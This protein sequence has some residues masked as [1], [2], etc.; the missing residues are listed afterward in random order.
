MEKQNRNF[1]AIFDMDGVIIDNNSHHKQAWLEFCKK[2]QFSLAEDGFNKHIYGRTNKDILNLLFKRELTLDDINKYAEEKEAMYREIYKPHISLP[3]GLSN[4]LKTLKA[5]GV[6]T[7]VA[8]SAPRKNVDF[9]FEN[10]D[11]KNYFDIIV[12]ETYVV[13]NKPAP[14]IYLKASELLGVVPGKCVVIEDSIPGITA[15][16]RAGMTVVAITT[17]L[18]EQDLTDAKLIIKTFNDLSV[19]KLMMSTGM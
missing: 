11:I 15:A 6:K 10:L 13:N 8:T 16:K 3:D 4:L 7:A 1:A 9:V 14:D 12:D 17:T 5:T 19:E 2:Y 18:K